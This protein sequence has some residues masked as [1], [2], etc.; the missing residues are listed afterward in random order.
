MFIGGSG[1]SLTEILECTRRVNP[2][3]RICV[4]A[5]VLENAARAGEQMEA[6]G[7]KTEVS[8]IMTASS[9]NAGGKHMMLG[10]NP[11][12]LITGGC[13]A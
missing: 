4:S 9:R 2:E 8:Q 11:V 3:A 5:I 13:D 10:G 7:W 6:L 12:W 1:G